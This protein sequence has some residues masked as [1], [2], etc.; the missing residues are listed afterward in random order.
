MSDLL[1]TRIN[2]G[3]RHFVDLPEVVFFDDFYEHTEELEENQS[4]RQA[5]VVPTPLVIGYWL[6][7]IVWSG[8]RQRHRK[9]RALT[10]A[11]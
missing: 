7:L 11:R 1:K 3:W 8:N 9:R 10:F 5:F 6:F 2:E 4:D